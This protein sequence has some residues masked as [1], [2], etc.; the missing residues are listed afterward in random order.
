MAI[1]RGLRTIPHLAP[2]FRV[3]TPNGTP[4][5]SPTTTTLPIRPQ[6]L[7]PIPLPQAGFWQ[8]L[9]PPSYDPK[10]PIVHFIE[11]QK[12]DYTKLTTG[13]DLITL[14]DELDTVCTD[15]TS[16]IV[17][18]LPPLRFSK[19][20]TDLLLTFDISSNVG[21][22]RLV[23]YFHSWSS[24]AQ[25]LQDLGF[26]VSRDKDL[27][28]NLASNPINLLLGSSP[29]STSTPPQQIGRNFPHKPHSGSW[30]ILKEPQAP[31]S[32]FLPGIYIVEFQ[33]LDYAQLALSG[34]LE[35]LFDELDTACYDPLGKIIFVHSYAH[36]NI[37]ASRP[38]VDL[39]LAHD[40]PQNTGGGRFVHLFPAP[41]NQELALQELDFS[42]CR[43]IGDA[44]NLA[45][46][47][48]PTFQA[49]AQF[50]SSN[51]LPVG[52]PASSGPIIIP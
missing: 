10:Y 51:S 28:A 12:P 38:V 13:P 11:F 45:Q 42:V 49:I 41:A 29:A 52:M 35:V 16:R 39:L 5:S 37:Q 6:T 50:N 7:P 18:E 46:N 23:H 22:G 24:K 19:E 31:H 27:A 2:H 26:L 8:I 30:Q 17:L 43:F 48:S 3:R 25:A 15:P 20:V 21:G 34:D 40:I 4:T 1:P 36:A 14:M 47:P 32:V 33:K 44:I 9:K